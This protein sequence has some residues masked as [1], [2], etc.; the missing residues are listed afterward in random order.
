MFAVAQEGSVMRLRRTAVVLSASLALSGS[1]G[2]QDTSVPAPETIAEP[3]RVGRTGEVNGD[4]DR[5]V[6]P[7]ACIETWRCLDATALDSEPANL[8]D[9]IPTFEDEPA[10]RPAPER[11]IAPNGAAGQAVPERRVTRASRGIRAGAR[12]AP[13]MAQIQRPVRVNRLAQRDLDWEDRQFCGGAYIAPGWIVTAAHCLKDGGVPIMRD[14]YRVRLGVSNIERGETG[15]TYKIVAV[16]QGKGYNPSSYAN[17]I[18]LIRFAADSQTE[19]RRIA[20]E[21]VRLDGALP[22][23]R[24]FAGKIAQFYGWGRTERDRPSGPLQFG[25]IRLLS[26]TDCNGFMNFRIALCGQG[27]GVIN[28]TQCHGDSGGPLIWRDEAKRAVLVGV[29]S[30][31]TEITVCGRQSKPGVFT[32]IAAHKAW[33][34]GYTGKLP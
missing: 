32:R 19:N 23:A 11:V 34:E 20:V 25:R 8:V 31:N 26:D 29:V 14:G 18:A 21:R 22:A 10:P 33:I 7:R 30:H 3:N 5:S 4:L 2:A 17:D 28:A 16:Y 12:E 9:I 13:W 24:Q 1:L 6:V 27:Y 15:A